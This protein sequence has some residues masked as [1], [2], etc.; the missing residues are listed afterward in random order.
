MYF[1]SHAHY[2][3]GRFDD[4]R[5]HLLGTLLPE[6]G[7]TAVLNVGAS[8]RGV[9]QSVALAEKYPYIYATVGTH[10]HYAKDLADVDL[11]EIERLCTHPKVVAVG[12]IG[13]DYFHNF[14]PKAVQVQRFREQLEIVKRSGLPV[15]LHTRDAT[16]EMFDTIKE[17]TTIRHGVV[18][19]FSESMEMAREYVKLGFY[20]G[21]GGMVTFPKTKMLIEVVR[22]TP[23]NRILLETDC[24]YLAP[25]PN[26]G[27]RNTSLNLPYIA[28]KIAEIKGVTTEEVAEQTYIN[29]KKLFSI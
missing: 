22:Q 8:M 5:D 26:R 23:L 13:L 29:G 20:I 3:D 19:C 27:Q 25:A 9:R 2:D 18:H 4:D 12:E 15:V 16:K 24:P 6:A 10:P 28:A 17:H 11:A 14:S 7:I 1:E 21:V